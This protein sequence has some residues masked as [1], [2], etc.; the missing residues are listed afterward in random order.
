MDDYK[1]LLIGR[2]LNGWHAAGVTKSGSRFSSS[3]GTREGYARDADD[4]VL[5]YCADKADVNSFVEFIVKGPMVDP[6]LPSDAVNPLS[7]EF[8]KTALHMIPMLEGGF[9]TL[10]ILAQ[11]ER[12]SSLDLVGL[13]IYEGLLRKV[14]G[15]RIGRIKSKEVVWEN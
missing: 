9:R 4:G 15:I 8:R 10:A 3:G 13:G 11:N 5:V 14:P 2:G 6:A 7:G 12:F 1:I